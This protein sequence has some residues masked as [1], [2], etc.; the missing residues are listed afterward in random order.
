MHD[1]ERRVGREAGA[2]TRRAVITKAISKQL[3]WVQAAEI[4]GISARH[5]RRLRWQ[6]RTLGH[7]GGDGPARRAAAAQAHQGR[8]YRAA[9][10]AQARRLCRFLAAPFL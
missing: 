6:G 9:V 4:L 2:M 8:D 10:P 1:I 7:V 3:S 5:M